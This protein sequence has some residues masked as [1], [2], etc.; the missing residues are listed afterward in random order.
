[1]ADQVPWPST[2]PSGARRLLTAYAGVIVATVLAALLGAIGWL[3]TRP[4]TWTAEASVLVGPQIFANGAS[5][6]PDMGTER[7]VA[8]SGAV[9]GAAADRLGLAEDVLKRSIGA[10]VPV[11]TQVLVLSASAGDADEAQR[12]AK[13]LTAAYVAY[14]NQ[15]VVP[16]GERPAGR[17]SQDVHVITPATAPLAPDSHDVVLVVVLALVLGAGLGVGT[18]LLLD[19]NSDLLRGA[20]DV[21]R[22]SGLAVLAR[23]RAAVHEEHGVATLHEHGPEVEAY[24]RLRAGLTLGGKG[25]RVVLVTSGE[26]YDGVTT[27][28]ANLAVATAESGTR[29]VLVLADPQGPRGDD[30][31]PGTG[32]PGLTVR[33]AATQEGAALRR[34]G[35]IARAIV[36]TGQDAV[37]VVAAPG[38]LTS[39][40]ALSVADLAH[41]VLVVAHGRR[42]G[43]SELLR[44][45]D[46]LAP[47][48]EKVQGVVLLV[49][50]AGW[51]L[52][53]WQRGQAALR[54]RPA[55]LAAPG[56]LES[57][58]ASD[59]ATGLAGPDGAASARPST[60]TGTSA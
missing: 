2:A 40:A 49:A 12:R 24:H 30:L 57:D 39:A 23:V 33:D 21:E 4:T 20:A 41:G 48:R 52:R 51:L 59:R 8:T 32:V 28:A 53:R 31:F 56:D 58:L 9:T 60:G 3:A 55:L 14:R 35:D 54:F 7:A 25:R 22:V 43:R 16:T 45:L 42:T 46:L 10:R 6:P 29:A 27:V 18:A 13:A 36:A 38:L 15:P 44:T 5:E 1:V 37:V 50:R 26:R 47:V 17:P 19:A 34:G 11:D